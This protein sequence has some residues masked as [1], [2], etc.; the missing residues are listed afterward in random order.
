L[1]VVS[2][3]AAAARASEFGSSQVLRP[4]IDDAM[5]TREAVNMPTRKIDTLVWMALTDTSFR[6]GLLNGKRR[7]LV[8]SLNLTEA[9]RQAVMAV[10]AETLEAFA[11]ALCQPAYCVS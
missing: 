9:E 8:A 6:E 2:S 10:R 7:E 4:N 1:S 11:G 3:T 5:D